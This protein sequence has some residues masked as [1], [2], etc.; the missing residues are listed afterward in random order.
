MWTI[1]H[2]KQ[3]FEASDILNC[4]LYRNGVCPSDLTE[5]EYL[6]DVL[7]ILNDEGYKKELIQENE[8]A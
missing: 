6:T 1:E 4:N 2:V 7:S 5:E 8:L 3:V